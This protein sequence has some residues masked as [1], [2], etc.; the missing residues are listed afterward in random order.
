[1]SWVKKL[2][3]GMAII[4][5]FFCLAFGSI[6]FFAY[7]QGP[8]PIMAETETILYDRYDQSIFQ[9]KT[10]TTPLKLE[11]ISSDFTD[12]LLVTEDKD[13]YKHVGFDFKRMLKAVINNIQAGTL[14]EG[15]STIT[16]QLAKN[17]YLSNEK[18]FERKLKEAFYTIRLE[19]FYDKETILATYMQ[20]I[21]F[22]HGIYG[23]EDASHY[24][25]Q[26]ESKDLT[27]A[28]SA[29]L[30]GIPKGPTYYS[31]LNDE[32]RATERQHFILNKLREEKVIQEADYVKA[33]QA[34][35]TFE[36]A[37]NDVSSARTY[38]TDYT[39]KE[40]TEILQMSEQQLL[41]QGLHIYTTFDPAI[42]NDAEKA[43]H[44]YMTD[45]ELQIGTITMDVQTGAIRSMIGGKDYAES[46]FNRAIHAN[47]MVGST[48]KPFLYYAA[49]EHHFT[50]SSIL[51]SKPTAFTTSE[52][53]LYEPGNF[54][55]YYA[56]GPITLMTALALS[57]N[58]YAVKT[59]VL[60]SANT[61][62]ETTKKFGITA[63]LP[64]VPSLALGT[65]SISLLEMTNGYRTIANSGKFAQS[66]TIEKITRPDGEVLYE[67][68]SEEEQV[69]D[70]RKNYILI[71]LMKGM[72]DERLNDYMTVTGASISPMLTREYAGKSGTTDA[73]SWM[74]G[75]SPTLVTGVWT[76]YDQNKTIQVNEEKLIAKKVWAETME[77]AH[78]TVEEVSFQKPDGLV[79]KVIDPKTGLLATD[80]CE[81]RRTAYF[82]KGTEPTTYCSNEQTNVNIPFWQ[83]F[84]RFSS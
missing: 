13:F 11:D 25:F 71:D 84:L 48:F 56:H 72:F 6:L 14:K 52:D 23:I 54:N 41:Q 30:A 12:A 1:M 18:T 43:V 73:D 5:F 60:L 50:P 76:G 55:D 65:A 24:F 77:R 74:I 34:T 44:T 68:S 79:K 33:K 20:S 63:P 3:L 2:C 67:H 80:Q 66:Y 69:L 83:L 27:L 46:S 45:S 4:L 39:L 19:M 53:T 17:L 42:Q 78:E 40:A 32:T 70:E 7:K 10:E 49:L 31:P 15:A 51:V 57:D 75:F 35:L 37:E 61:V 26:K 58:I 59:N 8:P 81:V 62:I 29:M 82:E 28:E 22:G 36:R 47:R 38:F 64:N 16:Q 9:N 21:Y